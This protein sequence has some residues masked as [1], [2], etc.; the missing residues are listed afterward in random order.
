MAGWDWVAYAFILFTSIRSFLHFSNLDREL[1]EEGREFGIGYWKIVLVLF[2]P[3]AI[4][5]AEKDYINEQKNN[6]QG[7]Q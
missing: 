2:L 5:Q 4:R 3:W 6:R 7:S 1:K